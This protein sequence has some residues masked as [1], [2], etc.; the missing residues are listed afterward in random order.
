MVW[1]N[2]SF[3]KSIADSGAAAP[4]IGGAHSLAAYRVDM[5]HLCVSDAV[6]LALNQ[7]IGIGDPLLGGKVVHDVIEQKS[8]ARY[9][10]TRSVGKIQGIGIGNCIPSLSI[11]EKCV[12]SPDS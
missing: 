7:S 10:D 11:T 8:S 12:V 5:D 9:R 1:Q 4:R 3:C 6:G 2:A